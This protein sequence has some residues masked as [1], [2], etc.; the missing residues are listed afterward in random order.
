M[1]LSDFLNQQV[2]DYVA[3]LAFALCAFFIPLLFILR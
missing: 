3:C 1:S 2:P